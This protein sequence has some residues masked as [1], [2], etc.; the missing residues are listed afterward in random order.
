MDHPKLLLTPQADRRARGAPWVFAN[1]LQM[2]AAARALP[3]GGLVALCDSTGRHVGL[4]QFNPHSLIAARLLSRNS[5]AVVDAGFFLERLK[6]ALALRA[7]LFAEPWYRL[8][9]AEGDGLPGLVIDRY[10]SALVVQPNTAGMVRCLPDILAALEALLAP[11]TV[12]VSG[13][14]P[15]RAQEGLADILE[16]VKGQLPQG[17]EVREN[18][19]VYSCDPLN[20]QKTGWFYDHRRNRA[21]V[22]DLSAGQSVLDVYSYAG[23]FGLLAAQRGAAAVTCVDRSKEATARISAAAEANGLA[24]RVTVATAEAFAFLEADKASYGLVIADPP[25]FAKAKK[26]VPVALKG[27][28]KL[29]KLSALR[30]APDGFLALASCSHHAEAGAF[31]AAC[32]AGLKA[33][34]RSAQLIHSAGAAPDHPVH[35][36]LP[37]TAYLK[38]LVYRLN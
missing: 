14:G 15:A 24:D 37:Q 16:V 29:A 20:G 31:Q 33:A 10:G 1:D 21:F 35:P 38:F 23:G 9:H 11:E 17:L 5:H 34:G 30:V 4:A 18:G 7:R 36:A 3:P 13:H 27:Y 2:N 26:D 12:I 22:A 28:E 25:A 8:V 6:R 19:L 32:T